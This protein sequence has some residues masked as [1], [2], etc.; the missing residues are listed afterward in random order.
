MGSLALVSLLCLPLFY[1]I[2]VL[3]FQNLAYAQE[4]AH[5]V[6]RWGILGRYRA[7]VPLQKV[8]AVVIHRNPLE[9]MLG[10]ARLTVYVAGGSPSTMSNLP[11]GEAMRLRDDL[12]SQA[13]SSHFVW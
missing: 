6:M 3:S 9:R 8:Q 10:L 5:I 1:A 13:A 7:I 11:S 2:G 4:G 12:A